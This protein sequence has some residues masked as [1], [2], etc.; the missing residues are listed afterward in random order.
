MKEFEGQ[1]AVVTGAASGIGLAIS[2]KLL[3]EG[4]RVAILDINETDVKREFK[5]F[6]TRSRIFPIDVTQ[7]SLVDD[8]VEEIVRIF[9]KIDILINCAGITGATN[10]LSH[11][12]SSEDLHKVFELNFMSCFYTSKAV[13]P[14]MLK[15]KY[16]RILHIASI[17]GKEGNVKM[18]AYSSSKAALIGMTKVQGKEGRAPC[19]GVL[20]GKR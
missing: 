6:K 17:A 16:G 5:K 2:Q 3:K 10:G 7:Q 19:Q 18:L 4:A 11:E 14:H 15:A 1:V 20:K 13:L 9:G 12:V 8:T